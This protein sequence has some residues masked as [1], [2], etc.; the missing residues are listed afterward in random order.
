MLRYVMLVMMMMMVMLV[1]RLCK[2][3]VRHQQTHARG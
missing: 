3:R 1:R 2:R